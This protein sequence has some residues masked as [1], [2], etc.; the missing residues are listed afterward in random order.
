MDVIFCPAGLR[1]PL[2]D[3]RSRRRG[4]MIIKNVKTYGE[5]RME[6]QGLHWRA[7][8]GGGRPRCRDTQ[9]VQGE[10]RRDYGALLYGRRGAGRCR[11]HWR[12]AGAGAQ[13][14]ADGGQGGGDVR[15][16]LHG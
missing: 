14:G 16:A 10:G 7:C 5:R 1:L 11:L 8:S 3:H 4:L 2:A 12:L 6:G 13:G 15:R 9:N